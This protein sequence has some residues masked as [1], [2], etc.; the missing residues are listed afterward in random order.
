[1]CEHDQDECLK[2]AWQRLCKKA[3]IR[4][5][6]ADIKG[7]ST[8]AIATM[9]GVK[10]STITSHLTR[11]R[12]KLRNYYFQAVSHKQNEPLSPDSEHGSSKQNRQAI[13]TPKRRESHER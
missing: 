1:M 2:E 13:F 9:L 4:I 6:M 11:D 3:Q 5:L 7:Y 8:Q 10:Q 12:A